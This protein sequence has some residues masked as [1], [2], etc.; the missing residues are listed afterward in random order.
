MV[1]IPFAHGWSFGME[2]L[3][4]LQFGDYSDLNVM[5]SKIFVPKK[6]PT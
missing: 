2:D 5:L 1:N 4:D 6:L 3:V